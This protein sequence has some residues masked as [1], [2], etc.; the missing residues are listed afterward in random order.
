MYNERDK[1]EL[2]SENFLREKLEKR[3]KDYFLIAVVYCPLM[4]LPLTLLYFLLRWLFY[5]MG[6]GML[7]PNLA[8]AAS[9]MVLAYSSVVALRDTCRQRKALQ[10]GAFSVIEDKLESIRHVPTSH[11]RRSRHRSYNDEFHFES[12]KIY[13]INSDAIRGT[14]LHSAIEFS[15]KGDPFYLVVYDDRPD[16]PVLMYSARSYRAEK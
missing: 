2:L 11:A 8:L 7:V 9:I 16:K 12:G 13:T 3:A 14:R 1:R 10:N 6:V 4:L 15:S 5:Q